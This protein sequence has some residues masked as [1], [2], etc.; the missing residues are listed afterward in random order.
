MGDNQKSILA[1]GGEASTLSPL[2]DDFII[3]DTN[4]QVNA[5]NNE[6]N[7]YTNLYYN[8]NPQNKDIHSTINPTVITQ[9]NETEDILN[10]EYSLLFVWFIIAIIILVLT[11][12]SILSNELTNYI[13]YPALG[14]L[15]LIIFYIIKN[16]YIYFND[17]L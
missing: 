6:Y 11:V 5:F 12:V 2:I 3:K 10:R 1:A 15:I 9:V 7:K 14:F 13:L 8:S 4:G 16:I 17:L